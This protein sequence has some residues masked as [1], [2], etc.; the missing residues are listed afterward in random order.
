MFVVSV[1]S[2]HLP[3]LLPQD[4]NGKKHE[5]RISLEPWQYRLV[6]EAPWGF[7]RGCI[8]SDG[9]A[10]INRTGPYSYL[11]YDFCNKS[12]DIIDL[13][14]IACGLVGVEHRVTRWRGSWRVRINRR[15]SCWPHALAQVGVKS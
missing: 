4:A 8:R 9:C 11:S 10:F 14:T 12:K 15:R 1:Y 6:E 3:C 5:R 7:L 13:F 2:A